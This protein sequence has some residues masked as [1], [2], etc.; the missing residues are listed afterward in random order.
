MSVYWKDVNRGQNLVLSEQEGQEE[1]IGGYR[2]TKR[3][4]DAYAQTF[5]YDPDRSRKGFATIEDA[6]DYVEAFKPW[7]LHDVYDVTIDR[8]GNPAPDSVSTAATVTSGPSAASEEPVSNSASTATHSPSGQL[9]QAVVTEESPR[10]SWW[11]FW[12]KG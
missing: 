7:E 9:A 11:E 8:E 2:D 10:K 4:I 12:K 6:K 5:G 1:I 3:G